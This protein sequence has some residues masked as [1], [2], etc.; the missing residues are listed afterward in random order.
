MHQVL[1]HEEY[2]YEYEHKN[3]ITIPTGKVKMH[4]VLC[5]DE[6]EYESPITIPTGKVRMHQV[7]CHDEYE[8]ESPITPTGKKRMHQVLCH[9]YEYESPITPTSHTCTRYFVTTSTKIQSRRQ[10]RYGTRYS[11]TSN[12]I[13]CLQLQVL[14]WMN[15]PDI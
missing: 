5:H 4:Q 13:R 10:A 2:E 1:C 8:Y 11:V 15:Q 12:V 9:E 6:F 3:L 14:F 7:L